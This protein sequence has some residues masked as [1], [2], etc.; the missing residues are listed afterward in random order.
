MSTVPLT[1]AEALS[2]MGA[3]ERLTPDPLAV[4]MPLVRQAMK[5]KSCPLLP[6]GE[7]A[8][9]CLRSKRKRLTDTR[10]MSARTQVHR[11]GW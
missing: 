10:G 9:R 7:E 11:P 3:D 1:A 5:D 4:M 2:M 8:A 6:M